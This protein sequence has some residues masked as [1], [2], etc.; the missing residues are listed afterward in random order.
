[1]GESQ[2]ERYARRQTWGP[3]PPP[4]KERPAV[5]EEK[6]T[7]GVPFWLHPAK[8]QDETSASDAIAGWMRQ[9]SHLLSTEVKQKEIRQLL[10][11]WHPDKNSAQQELSTKVFQ[12]IQGKRD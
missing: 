9:R 12:F 4:S 11:Q 6:P 3:S 5:P 10:A 1:M 2:Q 7:E 8:F